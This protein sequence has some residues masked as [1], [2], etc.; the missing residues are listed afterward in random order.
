MIVWF[1]FNE[2]EI[3]RTISQIAGI[4]G[5]AIGVFLLLFRD[6]IRKNIFPNL[7]RNEAF[8]LLRLMVIL[9]WSIALA[10][11]LAWAYAKRIDTDRNAAPEKTPKEQSVGDDE[12]KTV[13]PIVGY[14]KDTKGN[15][16]SN[17]QVSVL[18]MIERNLSA[19]DGKFTL[20]VKGVNDKIVRLQALKSGFKPWNDYVQIPTN[21][22]IIQLEKE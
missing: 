12:D 6:V 14:V 21:N 7:S 16:I 11:I 2:L 5:F 18:G 19:E 10:G 13:Y 3:L 8:R 1:G 20:S 22:L 17:A 15:P 4:G 9:T